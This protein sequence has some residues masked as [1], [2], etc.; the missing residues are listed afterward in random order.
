MK[1]TT[2]GIGLAKNVF[3]VHGVDAHGKATLKKQLKE[4]TQAR[5]DG[6]ML[7]EFAA[8]PGRD[9][10]MW[11]RALLG[12]E[13]ARIWPYGQAN[14]A[15]VRQAVRQDQQAR[16]GR[17]RG[18]LRSGDPADHA[19]CTDQECRPASSVGTAPGAARV[20]EGENGAS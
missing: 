8:V 19:V 14:G 17:C 2:I 18:D 9:G 6:G 16:C 1:I 7:C 15:A 10:S 11:Q 4:A 12:K 3:Q 20:G 13:A 5:P